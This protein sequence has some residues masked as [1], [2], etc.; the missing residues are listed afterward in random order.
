MVQIHGGAG[1]LAEYEAER[2]FRD[3]RIYRIYEG[4]TQ[5]MQLVRSPRACC[6]SSPRARRADVYDILTGLSLVEVSSFVA[7][8]SAGLYLAQFGADVIRV[9]QIGGGQ[10]FHRWPVT[11]ERN[12]LSWENLN[13]AKEVVALDLTRPEG[14][15]LLAELVRKIGQPYHQPAGQGL[16]RA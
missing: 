2:F 15:E 1:Y 11:A 5:I 4:T 6:A 8:P 10:D 12:S 9:D 3:S 16:P 14:R 13:R 7:S